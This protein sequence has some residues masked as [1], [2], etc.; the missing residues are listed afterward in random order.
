MDCPKQ[1]HRASRFSKLAARYIDEFFKD[2]NALNVLPA[3][4]Y[5]KVSEH[6]QFY[7]TRFQRF[8]FH[9]AI[10][11]GVMHHD[12]FIHFL[13]PPNASLLLPIP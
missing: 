3:T 6:M 9:L 7:L 11:Q 13:F 1:V 5:P 2:V 12:R 8:Q 10:V 4:K